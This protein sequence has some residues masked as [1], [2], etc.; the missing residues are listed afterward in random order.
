M[1]FG[2]RYGRLVLITDFVGVKDFDGVGTFSARASRGE[3][4]SS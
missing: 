3:T 2:F 1:S 4:T